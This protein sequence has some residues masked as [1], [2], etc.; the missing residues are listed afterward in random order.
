M[1]NLLYIKKKVYKHNYQIVVTIKLLKIKT[2]FTNLYIVPFL[3]LKKKKKTY[4]PT[5]LW[6]RRINEFISV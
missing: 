6:S 4:S 2:S 3:K 5:L 1:Q